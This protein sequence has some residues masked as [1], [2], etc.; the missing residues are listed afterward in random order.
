[1]PAVPAGD[2]VDA[3]RGPAGIVAARAGAGVVGDAAVEHEDLLVP[4][5]AV[6]RDG[7]ARRVAHEDG[8]EIAL[9]PQ[10]LPVDAG[11]ALLPGAGGGGRAGAGRS[12]GGAAPTPAAPPTRTPPSA[13]HTST[14][15][16]HA[17]P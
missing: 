8:L 14:W 13:P 9:F 17:S 11:A 15:T 2:A 1:M 6:P 7:G 5:V 10:D 4:E 3:P 16:Q 12:R